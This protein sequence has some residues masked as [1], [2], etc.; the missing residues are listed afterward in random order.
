MSPSQKNPRPGR[1][2]QVLVDFSFSDLKA[3]LKI[4]K[5]DPKADP[6]NFEVE[7][8][9]LEALLTSYHDMAATA[10]ALHDALNLPKDQPQRTAIINDTLADL[11]KRAN[12]AQAEPL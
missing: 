6:D 10:L 3:R 1:Q 4:H 7:I 5:L 9:D 2:K 11:F 8:L 12:M